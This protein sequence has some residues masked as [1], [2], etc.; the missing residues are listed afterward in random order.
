[1]RHGAACWSGSAVSSF[2]ITWIYT[3]AMN[4]ND[5]GSSREA[6]HIDAALDEALAQ[7]FPASDPVAVSFPGAV[8]LAPG[9]VD[10]PPEK[11][12]FRRR[13]PHLKYVSKLPWHRRP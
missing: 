8:D 12:P 3:T 11:K 10:A 7:S 4:K 9:E 1:M 5:P 6:A 2:D 13:S